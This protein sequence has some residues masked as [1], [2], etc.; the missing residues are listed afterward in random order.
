MFGSL[1]TSQAHPDSA[2]LTAFPSIFVLTI[3]FSCFKLDLLSSQLVPLLSSQKANLAMPAPL[4]QTPIDKFFG[5]K[6]T[7]AKHKVKPAA[8]R[9]KKGSRPVA[10][11]TS[12][13]ATLG[14][15]KSVSP[16]AS[17]D[18]ETSSNKSRCGIAHSLSS[19]PPTSAV[20][21]PEPTVKLTGRARLSRNAKKLPASLIANAS[22]SSEVDASSV[23]DFLASDNQ[24]DAVTETES[25]TDCQA[26]EESDF[27]DEH[28]ILPA[29]KR[30]KPNIKSKASKRAL[31][32][33][34]FYQSLVSYNTDKS[35]CP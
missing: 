25:V 33:R 16:P 35:S 23:S 22:C 31:A 8:S 30:T 7:M 20:N 18:D 21:T 17:E 14:L 27:D 9:A 4:K 6:T 34:E 29:A 15:H 12:I 11:L 2:S 19:T 32:S 24:S 28:V 3:I 13:D 5:K 26:T 10:G 1:C